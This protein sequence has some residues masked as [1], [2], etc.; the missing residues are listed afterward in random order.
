MCVHVFVCVYV[1][2]CVHVCVHVFCACRNVSASDLFCGCVMSDG[3]VRMCAFLLPTY[4]YAF[5]THTLK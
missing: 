5:M 1:C 4:M 3:V 2:V